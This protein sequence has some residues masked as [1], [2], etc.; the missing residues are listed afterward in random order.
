MAK[1]NYHKSVSSLVRKAFGL[2]AILP[3]LLLSGCE[4]GEQVYQAVYTDVFDTVTTLRGYATS[5]EEFQAEADRVHEQLLEYHQLFNIYEDY[6]GGL[7]QVNDNAGSAPVEVAPEV[8][9]L[10]EDCVDYYALTDGRVNVAMG[11]VLRLW[12]DAR[13]AGLLD[14]AAAKLPEEHLLQEAAN[15]TDIH[16]LQIH[17]EVGTVYLADGLQR[18]DVGAVAK[19]WAAQQ[20]AMALPDGYLL[21]LGGNVCARG[22]KPNGE[23]WSIGVQNPDAPQENICIVRISDQALVTSGDYQRSYSVGGQSYHHIIDPDTLYP[24][25]LWRSV[26]ILCADSALADCLSTALFLMP[27]EQGTALA[28]RAG[29]EAMWVDAQGNITQ[30]PGFEAKLR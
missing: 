9:A 6:P 22:T 3:L 8:I 18:L 1:S 12:H 4:T 23:K 21:N 19:G 7:K 2:C 28:E 5:Q 25:A 27:L 29:A 16:S 13:E 14:P 17:R 11:S 24:G 30:T 10:L 15:H 20:V 26:S